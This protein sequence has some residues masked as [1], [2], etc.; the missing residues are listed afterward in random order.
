MTHNHSSHEQDHQV[1]EEIH[2]SV[3]DA[4][5]TVQENKL[6][7]NTEEQQPPRGLSTNG[8]FADEPSFHSKDTIYTRTYPS[9][10]NEKYHIN[11]MKLVTDARNNIDTVRTITIPSYV[12]TYMKDRVRYEAPTL[13]EISMTKPHLMCQLVASSNGKPVTV[14]DVHR[15][16]NDPTKLG[17]IHGNAFVGKGNYFSIGWSVQTESVI[18]VYEI[19]DSKEY[20]NVPSTIKTPIAELTCVLVGYEIS[21]WRQNAGFFPDH[22]YALVEATRNRLRNP[23]TS[24][25]FYFDM[26]RIVKMNP[27]YKS[28]VDDILED[29]SSTPH[30]HDHDTSFITSVMKEILDIR[31]NQYHDIPKSEKNRYV[32]PL[33]VIETLILDPNGTFVDISLTPIRND[34]ISNTTF[35]LRLTSQNFENDNNSLLVERGLTLNTSSFDA[36]CA[37]FKGKD[38]IVV[39]VNCIR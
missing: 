12:R 21:N 1:T 11:T 7:V 29:I 13:S 3:H 30:G 35:Q 34:G 37:E 10:T 17:V 18:L 32:L 39:Q 19:V 9:Y 20:L 22:I 23:N 25:P 14:E 38:T 27:E 36:L 8:I 4:I 5:V 16:M 33:P 28:I 15:V 2:D 6:E 24:F 26:F 31:Y